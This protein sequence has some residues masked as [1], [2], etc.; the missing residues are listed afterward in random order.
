MQ[1]GRFQSLAMTLSKNIC[2]FRFLFLLFL[3]ILL[4]IIFLFDIY[5]SIMN[6]DNLNE[7]L[8]KAFE[9]KGWSS[10]RRKEFM[11]NLSKII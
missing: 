7:K 11:D 5:K 1:M 4:G 2:R 9:E 3:T 6:V 10:R 8:N